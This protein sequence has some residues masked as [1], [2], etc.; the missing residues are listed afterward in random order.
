VWDYRPGE[1]QRPAPCIGDHLDPRRVAGQLGIERRRR[2]TDIVALR[3]AVDR[4]RQG[5]P[6]QKRLV[7]LY[8]DHGVEPSELGTRRHLGDPVGSGE[9]ASVGQHRAYLR[10]LDHLRHHRRVGGHDE[11]I[12]QSVLLDALYD[13]GD[14]RFAGQHLERFV[15][16]S[17]RA[18]TCRDDT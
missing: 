11:F 14:Q 4:A 5:L 10:P 7:A 16:E 15:G 13:P 3:H 17:G 18:K 1:I 9:V 2:G 8:I 12:R 6:G